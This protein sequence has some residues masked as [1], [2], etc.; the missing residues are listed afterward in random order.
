MYK[1][2]GRDLLAV[3]REGVKSYETGIGVKTQNMSILP[4]TH[5]YVM[6]SLF[7][8]EGTTNSII[9]EKLII[10]AE[11]KSKLYEYF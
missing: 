5:L 11:A 2:D 3:S 10:I 8:Q 1:H 7:H 4:K 6:D 9:D